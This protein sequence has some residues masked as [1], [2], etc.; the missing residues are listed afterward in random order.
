[1][2]N[3]EKGKKAKKRP[4]AEKRMLQN[5]RCRDR[6]RVYKSKLRTALRRFEDSLKG[7]DAAVRQESL[8][9]AF[10]LL[11]KAGKKGIYKPNKISR[12]KSRLTA[13]L[14]KAA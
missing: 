5:V 12:T 11:D 3:E 13:R 1:M 2:A 4:T 14:A 9:T 8:N 6:N 7:A 10:S